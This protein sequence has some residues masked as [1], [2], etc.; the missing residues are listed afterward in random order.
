MISGAPKAMVQRARGHR[1]YYCAADLRR[2]RDGATLHY[3]SPRSRGGTDALA[4]LAPACW[5]CDE[6]KGGL[7]FGEFRWRVQEER[8]A[9]RATPALSEL[10]ANER[11]LASPR[12]SRL[13]WPGAE[14]AGRF[15]FP[16]VELEAS[17]GGRGLTR[18]GEAASVAP[19]HA[20]G[21]EVPPGCRWPSAVA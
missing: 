20:G 12:A 14:R 18:V 5:P 3:R 2:Y 10:L 21:C 7:T 8:P 9:W 17:A 13:L 6:A 16:G 15:T 19:G 11:A 1:C 4:N